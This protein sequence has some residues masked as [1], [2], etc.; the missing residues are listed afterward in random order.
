VEIEWLRHQA[1]GLVQPTDSSHLNGATLP[2]RVSPIL[3]HA[4]RDNPVDAEA[5]PPVF[6]ASLAELDFHHV[7]HAGVWK[8]KKLASHLL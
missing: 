6:S 8:T 3:Q 7:R 5:T 2:A 1:F 4:V